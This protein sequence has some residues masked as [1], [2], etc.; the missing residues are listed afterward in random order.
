MFGTAFVRLAH[1]GKMPKGDPVAMRVAALGSAICMPFFSFML[2]VVGCRTAGE[3]SLWGLA[4][5]F[6]LDC[7]LNLPFSFFEERPFALFAIGRG[8]HMVS[9]CLIGAVL[10][11]LCGS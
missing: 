5:A 10:G 3:G 1:G 11:T 6:F 9:L 8:Y 4:I 2:S 7:G